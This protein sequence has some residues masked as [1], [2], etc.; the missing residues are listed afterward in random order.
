MEEKELRKI[1]SQK[2]IETSSIQEQEEV[3]SMCIIT[4]FEEGRISE[5]EYYSL[6]LQNKIIEK[7]DDLKIVVK[8]CN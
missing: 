8:S 6:L 1:I 5:A 7:L 2:I 3:I 4:A